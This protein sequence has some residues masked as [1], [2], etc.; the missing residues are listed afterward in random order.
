M[1]RKISHAS[2][3]ALK[4]KSDNSATREA[5]SKHEKQSSTNRG[6]ESR[7]KQAMKAR[8]QAKKA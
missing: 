4:G 6:P 8:A 7:R 2:L 1:N 3:E 5:L